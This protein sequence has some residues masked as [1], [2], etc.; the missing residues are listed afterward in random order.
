MPYTTH[1]ITETGSRCGTQVPARY[2][3]PVISEGVINILHVQ[4]VHQVLA[5]Q[6]LLLP[7]YLVRVSCCALVFGQIGQG[8]QVLWILL[9][10]E[11]P[12]GHHTRNEGHAL[13]NCPTSVC[14]ISA[15]PLP[16]L[17]AHVHLQ[18]RSLEHQICSLE[19][20]QAIQHP[21]VHVKDLS[22]DV[23]PEARLFQ[24]ERDVIPSGYDEWKFFGG[25]RITEVLCVSVVLVLQ[26]GMIR[27]AP[28]QTAIDEQ[29]LK[30]R[31]S[32]LVDGETT[33]EITCQFLNKT[34]HGNFLG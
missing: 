8:L 18:H 21:I 11:H 7:F 13:H 12:T 27:F 30:P 2:S 19:L 9:E 31:S 10:Q 6:S 3:R 24:Q 14:V 4:V 23:V 1:R 25:G 29:L 33:S 5:G 22:R 28:F 32:G 26:Q 16:L 34:G 17:H 20:V 15:I